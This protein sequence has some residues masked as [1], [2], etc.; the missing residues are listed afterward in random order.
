MQRHACAAS[1][2][3]DTAP[4]AARRRPSAADHMT[5]VRF[6]ARAVR[7]SN[8][9]TRV[10]CWLSMAMIGKREAIITSRSRWSFMSRRGESLARRRRQRRLPALLLGERLE[11]VGMLEVELGDVAQM[12][13]IESD[14]PDL[15]QDL[16]ELR[17]GLDLGR[18]H[19]AGQLII[20]DE[21][22]IG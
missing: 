8:C 7:A 2:V 16:Q 17:T 4:A 18:V 11:G 13:G 20:G 21:A 1:S 3:W 22:Q 10:S 14:L 15:V 5:S 12:L 6:C 9:S 19:G